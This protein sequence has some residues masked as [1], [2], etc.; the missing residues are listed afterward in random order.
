MLIKPLK[1]QLNNFFQSQQF[2]TRPSLSAAMVF[3]FLSRGPVMEK[4][5]VGMG[6]M[7]LDALQVRF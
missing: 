3:A 7:N 5:I 4:Q 1:F 2:A 6:R